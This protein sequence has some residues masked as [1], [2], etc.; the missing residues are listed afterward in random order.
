MTDQPITSPAYASIDIGSN[1]FRLLIAQRNDDQHATTPWK[2]IA[3]THRIIRLGEGLHQSGKLCDAAMQRAMHAFQE[4]SELLKKHHIKASH[5]SVVATA[6]MREAKNGMRFCQQVKEQTGIHIQIIEGKQEANLSLAGSCAVLPEHLRQDLL[7]FDIGGGSTE[8]VRAKNNKNIDAIS[9]KMGVVR[10]VETYLHSNPPSKK[11]YKAMKDA[12]HKHLDAVESHWQENHSKKKPPQ[13]LVGTAGTVTTL[14][15]ID[16]EL[17]DY[18]ADMVNNHCIEKQRFFELRDQLLAMNHKQRQ[19]I[20]AI[21]QGRADLMIAGIAIIESIFER[22]HYESL[23]TVDAGLLEGA[24]L[25][26]SNANY[27]K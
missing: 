23:V 21:E 8:F 10:L 17:I 27:K 6:A 1:T 7:L 2:I 9:R 11:D 5:L 24:W 3:Y 26:I 18:D 16:L 15:A 12:C 19:A 25:D 4:F 20:P 22:W 13:H 14:A